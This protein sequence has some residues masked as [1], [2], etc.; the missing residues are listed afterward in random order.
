MSLID[1]NKTMVF[2]IDGTTLPDPSKYDYSSQSLDVSAERDTSGLLHRKMVATKFNVAL[3][4]QALDYE[5]IYT[6]LHL[7]RSSKFT[8]GFPCPEVPVNVNAG[9]HI[10]QYYCGDRKVT[11]KKAVGN[12]KTKW[13]GSLSFDLI[14]Y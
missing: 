13:I 1:L 10:G 8:F 6:I 7:V 2:T 11:I 14:E 3:E 12:D 4:W 9:R 5:T